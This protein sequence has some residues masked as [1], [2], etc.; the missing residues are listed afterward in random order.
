MPTRSSPWPMVLA[1]GFLLA[2]CLQAAPAPP[3]AAEAGLATAAIQPVLGADGAPVITV[4]GLLQ[5][6]HGGRYGAAA[7]WTGSRFLVIGGFDGSEGRR[8]VLAYEPGT[9]SASVV[10]SLPQG[11]WDA[12]AAW[13]GSRAFVFGGGRAGGEATDAIVSVDPDTGAAATAG[14]LPGAR[15]ST[16]AASAD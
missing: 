7:V 13:D 2:G 6:E 9:A 12:S 15:S 4:A 11:T 16:G 8:E 14:T 5:G 10:A 1:A 3:A